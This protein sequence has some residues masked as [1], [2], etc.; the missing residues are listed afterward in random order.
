MSMKSSLRNSKE[1]NK[2]AVLL[3]EASR[4]SEGQAKSPAKNDTGIWVN[5]EEGSPSK[6]NTSASFRVRIGE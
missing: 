2:D 5:K 3:T 1:I 6:V 4:L